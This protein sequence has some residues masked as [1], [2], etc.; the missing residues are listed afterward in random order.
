[1]LAEMHAEGFLDSLDPV[2]LNVV[3]LS[4]IYEPRRNELHLPPKRFRHVANVTGNF[5][6]QIHRRE[7]KFQIRPLTKEPFFHLAT[8]MEKWSR[9]IS[10]EELMKSSE[11]DE[12]EL[13]RYYRMVIQL[14]RELRGA[15]HASPKLL[16]TTANAIRSINRDVVD[17]EKQLRA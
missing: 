5:L 1:M 10:F 14:L 7:M 9:G 4:L 12:G 13:I 17:A 11:V 6:R 3:L 8:D 15:P 16:E 2:Q